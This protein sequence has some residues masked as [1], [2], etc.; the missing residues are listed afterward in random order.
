MP[1]VKTKKALAKR[2]KVTKKKKVLRSKAGRRHILSG[3]TSKR[4][5]GLRKRTTTTSA[6]KKM[7][8]RSLPYEA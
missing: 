1:K 3:K 5:R 2:V 6:E 7:I 8:K 4:K